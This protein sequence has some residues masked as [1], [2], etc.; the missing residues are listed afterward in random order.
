MPYVTVSLTFYV[1]P[2]LAPERKAEPDPPHDYTLTSRR[3]FVSSYTP[4]R[5]LAVTIM[6]MTREVMDRHADAQLTLRLIEARA[7]GDE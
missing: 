3:A 1:E 4:S 7:E 6:E 2:F 5:A